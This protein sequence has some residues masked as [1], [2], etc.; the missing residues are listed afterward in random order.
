[1]YKF[2]LILFSLISFAAHAQEEL[3]HMLL[4]DEKVQ[5]EATDAVN[6]MYNFK[7]DKAEM[8]FQVLKVKYPNHPLPYF[9]MGLSTWWKMYPNLEIRKRTEKYDHPFVAYMDTAIEYAEKLYD[10]NDK[11]YEAIFFLAGAYGF[12]AHLY[13]ERK[14][15]AKA[16]FAA[17]SALIYLRKN[18]DNEELSPE[19]LFGDALYN[20]YAEW[21]R[22]NYPLLRPILIFFKGGDKELGIKQL[23]QVSYNAFY[24]RTEAQYYLMRIYKDEDMNDKALTIA[25]YLS[26]TFPDNGYFERMYA[27]LCYLTGQNREAEQVCLDILRKLDLGMQGYEEISGRFAGFILGFIYQYRD[28]NLP[29]AKLYYERAVKY[30]EEIDEVKQGYYLNSLANLARIADKQGDKQTARQYYKTLLKHADKDDQEELH[31]E[32]KTYL[33]T[34]KRGN[35]HSKDLP[36]ESA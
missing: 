22:E 16:T 34:N 27:Q 29:K 28:N 30:T 14:K 13:G 10:A 4:L 2:L 7:F 5:V 11:N 32:A 20:Y 31:D 26:T 19:F 3:P 15:Y 9:L 36:K 17:R 6:D 25:R 8:Q 21:I 12:K 24:T 18:V 33:K 35:K 23:R 1:M